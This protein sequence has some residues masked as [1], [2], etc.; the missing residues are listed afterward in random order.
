[1]KWLIVK[2]DIMQIK[3]LTVQEFLSVY[4]DIIY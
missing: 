2:R 4:F 3:Q 1:M